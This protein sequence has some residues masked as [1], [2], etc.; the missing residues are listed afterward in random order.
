M[1]GCKR[2]RIRIIDKTAEPGTAS[3]ALMV[4]SR[5]YNARCPHDA[6]FPI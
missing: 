6:V 5:T 1:L 2:G 3:R 4:Q